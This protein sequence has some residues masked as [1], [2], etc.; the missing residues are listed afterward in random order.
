MTKIT[1]EKITYA[2][3]ESMREF[4]YPDVTDEMAGEIM[5]AYVRKEDLPHGII[6]MML[7][8]QLSD[9]AGSVDLSKFANPKRVGGAA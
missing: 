4:G 7:E 9:L 5:D 6:G 1:R 2:L 3:A 8:S